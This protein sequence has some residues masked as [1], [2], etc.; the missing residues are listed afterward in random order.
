MEKS[1]ERLRGFGAAVK[2][3]TGFNVCCVLF[4][5][6]IR[7]FE[8]VVKSLDVVSFLRQMLLNIYLRLL[9]IFLEAKSNMV[10]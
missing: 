5:L 8:M 3:F 4:G 6:F 9:F 2:K 1:H 7:H 10:N